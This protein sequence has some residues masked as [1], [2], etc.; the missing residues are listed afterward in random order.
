MSTVP[1]F[2]FAGGGTGGHLFPALGV[3]EAL[4]VGGRAA[5]VSFFCT[6]RPIDREILGRAGLEA[7]PQVVRPMPSLK[8]PWTWPG[9]LVTWRQAVRACVERF[10]SAG[11]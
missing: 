5:D 8:R 1:W 9:F 10:R 4:R 3:V 7:F 11:R 6:Q 2:V